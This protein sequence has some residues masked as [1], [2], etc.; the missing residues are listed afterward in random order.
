MKDLLRTNT[1]NFNDNLVI[2]DFVS[3]IQSLSTVR[4]VI[5]FAF[6][7]INSST[8]SNYSDFVFNIKANTRNGIVSFPPDVIWQVKFPDKDIVGKIA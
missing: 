3:R 7:N 8:D 4:S 2:A 1:T 5:D 6:T